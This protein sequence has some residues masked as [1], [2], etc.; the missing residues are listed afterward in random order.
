MSYTVPFIKCQVLQF[1]SGAL[2]V[3]R[4]EPPTWQAHNQNT[5]RGLWGRSGRPAV[6]HKATEKKLL[7]SQAENT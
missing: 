1:S 3:L 7:K 4:A 6:N 5:A 2:L